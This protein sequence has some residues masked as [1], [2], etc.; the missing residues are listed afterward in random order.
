MWWALLMNTGS[1]DCTEIKGNRRCV[2]PAI[3][4][5]I[6]LE[7]SPSAASDQVSYY[8]QEKVVRFGQAVRHIL[9]HRRQN[10]MIRLAG[11][12][13]YG[14]RAHHARYGS[15]TRPHLRVTAPILPHPYP[16][17]P[18]R[19]QADTR[20]YPHR[21]YLPSAIFLVAQVCPICVTLSH[22]AA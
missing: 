19:E 7:T 14:C 3:P 15:Q 6:S 4:E 13:L 9:R 11:A 20:L 12:C 21:N 1:Q 17:H 18:D 5:P 10:A 2:F 16:Q 22:S 8:G